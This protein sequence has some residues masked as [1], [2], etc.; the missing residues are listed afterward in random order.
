MPNQHNQAVQQPPD[1]TFTAGL[2]VGMSE[3]SYHRD[4]VPGG[5]LSSTGARKIIQDCPAKFQH[6]RL[7]GR[8][9]KREFDFGHAAHQLVLGEGPELRR[10][11]EEI[12][13]TNGAI[14]TTEAKDFVNRA[15]EE[16]AV[17]LKPADYDQVQAM[18]QRIR[19]HPIAGPLLMPDAGIAE[20]SA[21]WR[22]PITG[23]WR[24]ARFDWTRRTSNRLY[25]VDYKTSRDANPEKFKK[26]AVDLGYHQQDAWYCDAVIDLGI[27]KDP[28]FLFVV[29]EKTAPYVVS[30]VQL[31]N[32]AR[33]IGRILNRQAIDIYAQCTESGIWPGY[34]DHEVALVSLPYWYE[35]EFE[36]Q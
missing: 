12:L 22:D 18:A 31:D 6:E 28:A 35:R 7:H 14:S 4:P 2:Y 30:V 11:P 29:Q 26:T 10:I 17:P 21:F 20:Q 1:P 16:C 3:E 9:A 13:A 8:P 23:I 5:S 15:R 19:E 25:L 27:D 24:R 36:E 34:H 33:R 32:N